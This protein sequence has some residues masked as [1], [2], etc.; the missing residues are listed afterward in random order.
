MRKNW[1]SLTGLFLLS[2]IMAGCAAV[3]TAVKYRNLETN[4]RMS[5][6][7]M[8]DPVPVNRRVAWVNIGNTSDKELGVD[9]LVRTNLANRGVKV[10]SDSDQSHFR[11][12]QANVLYVGK[13]S[14]AAIDQT[15]AAGYGGALAGGLIGGTIGASSA[16]NPLA[17]AVVGGG[18]GAMLGGLAE[19]ALDSFVT[20]VTYTIVVDLQVA[21]WSD[22]AVS[23]TET[24]ASARGDSSDIRQRSSGGN[25]WKY[26]RTRI[27]AT[28][29]KVNLEFEEAKSVLEQNLARSMAGLLQ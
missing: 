14:Q 23:Q 8:L 12:L 17:G 21:E 27:V 16:R 9:G 7:V 22:T 19:T 20:A 18:I 13:A 29:T 25:N 2:F 3:S 26:Y 24:G 5:S 11:R 10:V 6:A 15:F 1:R 28:A 4:T